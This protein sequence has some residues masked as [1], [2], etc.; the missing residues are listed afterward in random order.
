MSQSGLRIISQSP[1]NCLSV[2]SEFCL[3]VVIE[4]P[5]SL[6]TVVS[7]TPQ[8]FLRAFSVPSQKL[9]QSY[10]R[11]VKEFLPL[12]LNLVFWYFWYFKLLQTIEWN[13]KERKWRIFCTFSKKI[14]W[15]FSILVHCV[16]CVCFN[17]HP[18]ITILALDSCYDQIMASNYILLYYLL[19]NW[20]L[21][22]QW[23]ILHFFITI[24]YGMSNLT[25]DK[26]IFIHYVIS[27][28]VC[29]D[30]VFFS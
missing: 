7:E 27:K 4:W 17:S 29:I 30:F 15:E 6:L 1:E 16:A 28:N 20:F 8:S 9:I 18:P 25:A 26:N 21:N 12:K 10:L 19:R 22:A 11:V 2:F 3:R 14:L 13:L 5:Q 24:F 23:N